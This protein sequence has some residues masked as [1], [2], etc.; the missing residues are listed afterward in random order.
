M[1]GASPDDGVITAAG[2]Y[3]R[4]LALSR[5]AEIGP[6]A[7]IFNNYTDLIEA[8]ESGPPRY[9]RGYWGGNIKNRYLGIRFSLNGQTHYGWIRLTV[10]SNVKLNKPTLDATIT[11]YAYETVP[12]KPILAGTAET[13]AATAN[14]PPAALQAPMNLQ[15]KTGPSLGMLAAGAEG[16]PLWRR[17]GVSAP[18]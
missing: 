7:A 1:W 2:F 12:N 13:A 3:G 14:K 11:G 8:T 9:S 6:S 15:G 5:G 18:Q 16:T 17:E 10:T 4:A